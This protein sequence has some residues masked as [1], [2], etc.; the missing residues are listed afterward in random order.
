MV[1]AKQVINSTK[2]V[3]A[4]VP[5]GDTKLGSAGYDNVRD[6]IEKTKSL[7]EGEVVK[8]PANDYDISNKK[9]VDDSITAH[10]G[11]A[12]AHSDYLLNTGDT[13]AG[14][15]T[16]DGT[17][18]H[19][20]STNNRVGIGT[21]TPK[22]DL[23]IGDIAH[24]FL[25][26]VGIDLAYNITR[27]AYYDGAWKR[28][29]ADADASMIQFAKDESIRFYQATDAGDTADS[30]VTWTERMRIA[31]GG[32]VGIGVT[33][34]HSKLE[35]A[36][37]ISSA[38]KTITASSD[39]VDVAG[40]NTVFINPGAAVVIGGFANGVIGQRV[41]VVVI[42]AD[43]DVTMENNEATGTQKLLMHQ[44]LDETLSSERG[45]WSFVYSGSYWYDISHARH[46]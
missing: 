22:T 13:A 16:F 20:D 23:Q 19:I 35:V 41:D 9:F 14:D 5:K 26:G 2:P 27:N 37:A 45:G 33:D 12:Q 39:A 7:R 28:T 11:T 42:D 30:A 32:N 1:S 8:V 46:V 36:G 15:Y 21:I 43:Q 40:V 34:P 6:D 10:A 31:A 25:S 38:V 44:Q 24:F 18:L 29:I 3:I 17:T 4:K